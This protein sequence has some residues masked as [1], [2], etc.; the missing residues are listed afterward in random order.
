MMRHYG[1]VKHAALTYKNE[2]LLGEN[3][4]SQ[5]FL[6]MVIPGL[7]NWI[8]ALST[9]NVQWGWFVYQK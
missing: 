2:E 3:G 8:S 4:I 1:A 6:D 9:N 5:D 7:S